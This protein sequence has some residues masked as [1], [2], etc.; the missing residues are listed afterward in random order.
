VT[1]SILDWGLFFILSLQETSA[2]LTG[3][4]NLFTFTGTA[5]FFLLIMPAIYWCWDSRLGLRIGLATLISLAVNLILK[6]VFHE[7]RPY[8]VD[9]QVRLLTEPESSFGVP[10]GHAQ[11]SV[12]IW[13]LL[14]AYLNRPWSW[15]A[16]I[17]IIV[18]TGLSRVYL[19]V[20]FPTDVLAGWILG[21]VILGLFLT[22][23]GRLTT[24][25]KDLSEPAQIGLMFAISVAIILIGALTS[26]AVTASWQLPA[27]WVRN[28][29]LQA[30][31]EP[32]N[33]LSLENLIITAATLFGLSSGAILFNARYGFNAGGLWTRRVARYVLGVLGVLILWQGLGTLFNLVSTEETL[34]GYMLC[35]VRFAAVGSWISALGPLLFLRF[36]LAEE[37]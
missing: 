3:P 19:G 9:P 37:Q 15:L 16:A 33:P 21:V 32:I 30:P 8:W 7:P 6:V 27:D 12:I 17:A 26:N 13:G 34:A 11:N 24:G 14:A 18:F 28:A 1:E 23:E 25:L 36:R 2:W 4:M 10:S 5:E 20:H 31:H 35:Y 29:A 22:F